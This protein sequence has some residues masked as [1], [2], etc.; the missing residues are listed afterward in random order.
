MHF[1]RLY[2]SA[3][4]SQITKMVN[5]NAKALG[6]HLPWRVEDS[7]PPARSETEG[8]T[9]GCALPEE[10]QPSLSTAN[11]AGESLLQLFGCRHWKQDSQDI[12]CLLYKHLK[13]VGDSDGIRSCPATLPLITSQEHLSLGLI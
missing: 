5:R 6:L 3:S 1:C 4:S 8:S 2:G 9:G 11:F 10:L 13:R 12:H 7:T